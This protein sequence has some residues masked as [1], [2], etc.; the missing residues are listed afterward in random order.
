VVGRTAEVHESFIAEFL[1]SPPQTNEVGRSG[2]LING[3]LEV[4]RATG[5]PLAMH[6]I[7]ASAGLN[8]NW[9][10]FRYS[11]AGRTWGDEK[12]AV[13]LKPEWQ[14]PPSPIEASL[15]VVSRAGCDIA[16]IDITREESRARLKAFIWPDQP[17]RLN[18]LEAAMAV[19]LEHP[20]AVEKEDALVWLRRKL[21][22][23]GERAATV[24]YHSSVWFYMPK[25]EREA[26]T[27]LIEETGRAATTDNPLAWLSFEPH[28]YSGAD[29]LILS[30]W[31]GYK[32]KLLA[33]AHPHGAWVEWL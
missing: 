27:A 30:L 26:I 8:L 2:V 32:K 16:P 7:G 20:V 4:A 12:S 25:E 9:D 24:I 17:E 21:K 15:S 23:R 28:D 14:G 10:R 5:L 6:E 31:P 33:K 11:L 22:D 18:R 13:H 1:K 29:M 3:F 19:A